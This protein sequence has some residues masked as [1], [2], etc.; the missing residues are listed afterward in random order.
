VPGDADDAADAIELGI[1][2]LVE[3]PRLVVKRARRRAVA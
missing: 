2:E 1:V 3:Q